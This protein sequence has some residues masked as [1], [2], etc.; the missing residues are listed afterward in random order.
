MSQ[1]KRGR[2][3]RSEETILDNLSSPNRFQ[4]AAKNADLGFRFIMP[5]LPDKESKYPIYYGAKV[6]LAFCNEYRKTGDI[7]HATTEVLKDTVQFYALQSVSSRLWNVVDSKI[8]QNRTP[9][10][11]EPVARNAFRTALSMMM[12]KGSEALEIKNR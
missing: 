10:F 2:I 8:I 3:S 7:E 11:F 12:Q 5:Y 4:K 1:S 9:V 6:G